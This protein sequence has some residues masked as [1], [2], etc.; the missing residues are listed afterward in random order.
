[1][2]CS[3]KV[4]WF[5]QNASEAIEC[6]HSVNDHGETYNLV[7]RRFIEHRFHGLHGF[8]SGNVDS[9][10]TSLMRRFLLNT[11]C[12]DKLLIL[13]DSCYL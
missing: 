10:L 11:D 9:P 7:M 3:A 2:F 12:T 4:T 8:V 5:L 1:M 13:G 6:S